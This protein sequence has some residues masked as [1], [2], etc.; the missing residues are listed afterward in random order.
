M[1][2]MTNA[3]AKKNGKRRLPGWAIALIVAAAL[4]ITGA[5]CCNT[6]KLPSDVKSPPASA[7]D[8]VKE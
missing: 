2:D 4:F 8:I 1:S 6:I 7:A 3:T 5:I